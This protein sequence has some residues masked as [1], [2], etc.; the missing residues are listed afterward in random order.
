MKETPRSDA[1]RLADIR[2]SVRRI[3]DEIDGR[4]KEEFLENI[5]VQDAVKFQLMA[6]GDAAG[7]ISKRTRQA[8]PRIPWTELMEFR[9]QP[10]HAYFDLKPERVWEFAQEHLHKIAG[11]LSK[12]K[13]ASES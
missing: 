3:V 13:V 12:V 6:L 4:A 10:A 11:R 5:T 9:Y 2:K 7:R 8:N 1:E